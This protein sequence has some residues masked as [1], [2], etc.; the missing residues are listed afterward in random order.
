MHGQTSVECE[1]RTVE[2]R[3]AMTVVPE[4]L[5]TPLYTI[6]EAARILRV[7]TATL[8]TW[9]RGYTRKGP[10]GTTITGAQLVSDTGEAPRHVPTMPFVGLAEAAFLAEVRK[11]G[12]PMQR[13]R[14]ALE[15]LKRDIGLDYALASKRL[16]TDG[17]EIL[18]NH[19]EPFVDGDDPLANLVVA[20]N[21]QGV[22]AP[23][24]E[25]FLK[26][27]TYGPSGYVEAFNLDAYGDVE[28]RVDP[29]I[30]FGRPFIPATGVAVEAVLERFFAG[31]SV[32]ELAN[33]FGVADGVVEQLI[34]T[35]GLIA[36]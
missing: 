32:D 36:A 24:I 18:Y 33:D 34:R 9:A 30:S 8:S 28:V 20:R 21:N 7:P 17:A 3:E 4:S 12:V 14:P 16:Y 25:R 26:N 5:T 10:R 6:G 11:T 15:R 19:P 22:F 35:S 29:R 2:R 23:V 1:T 13:I 31:D 27:I